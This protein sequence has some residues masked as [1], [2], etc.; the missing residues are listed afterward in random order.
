MLS[1]YQ[2]TVD[3][4]Q[5]ALKM[6][7]ERHFDA[8]T[9]IHVTFQYP[10]DSVGLRFEMARGGGL[11]FSE[12]RSRTYATKPVG[13]VSVII[14]V[15]NVSDVIYRAKELG[16]PAYIPPFEPNPLVQ[17]AVLLD[18]N[19]IRVRLM[20]VTSQPLYPNTKFQQGQ[21]TPAGMRPFYSSTCGLCLL[22]FFSTHSPS[23]SFILL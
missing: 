18:P 13:D 1:D 6:P 14:Y 8:G 16:F 22:P 2:R 15:D 21:L 7:I 19:G 4:W 9:R 5:G 17:A 20:Q 23:H 3:F 10:G 11:G 12:H